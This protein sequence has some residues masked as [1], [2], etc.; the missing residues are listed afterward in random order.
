MHHRRMW[1]STAQTGMFCEAFCKMRIDPEGLTR[2][3]HKANLSVLTA[4][5][6]L[7]HILRGSFA[8]RCSFNG[9]GV[10]RGKIP[11]FAQCRKR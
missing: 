2:I 8:V 6:D 9:R 7:Q 11:Q 5:E 3:S 1:Q 10:K 4:K